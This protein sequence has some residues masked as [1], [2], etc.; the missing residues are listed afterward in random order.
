[1]MKVST[2]LDFKHNAE[3]VIETY[4]EIFEAEVVCKYYYDEDMT[5]DQELIGK[6]FHAELK[7]GDLNLY[8]SDSG[9]SPSFASIKFVIE[10]HEENEA[11]KLFGNLAQNGKII[12]EFKKMPFGPTIAKLEDEFGIKWDVV[13]C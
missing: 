12:S 11:R 6:I 3:E 2:Y 13:I 9:T 7:I 8:V 5:Q 10:I 1:M 4:E